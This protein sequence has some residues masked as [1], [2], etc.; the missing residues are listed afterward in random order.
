MNLVGISSTKNIL[1]S[2]LPSQVI[3]VSKRN[4]DG[5]YQVA[6]KYFGTWFNTFELE[7]GKGYWFKLNSDASWSYSP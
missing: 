5:S 3:E 7:P 6:T 4:S 1:L 2:S